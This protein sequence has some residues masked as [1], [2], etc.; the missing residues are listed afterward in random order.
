VSCVYC[1]VHVRTVLCVY[2]CDMNVIKWETCIYSTNAHLILL[3]ILV[4]QPQEQ[5][6]HCAKADWVIIKS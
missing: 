1:I 2:M 3:F 4:R 6:F 5:Q